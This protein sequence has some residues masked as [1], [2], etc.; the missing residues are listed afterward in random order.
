MPA[1]R[2]LAR[3]GLVALVIGTIAA[4]ATDPDA[5]APVVT[6]E[7]PTDRIPVIID[8]DLD[9]SDIGAILVMLR[10]PALDVRA[11][12]ISGTGLIHCQA[13]RLVTRFLI[14]ELGD[15]DIPFGC[16][17]EKGGPDARP[18]PDDWRARAD[19]AF[20]FD[21]APTVE[22]GVPLDAVELIRETV[23]TSPSAPT[24]VALG[25]LTNLEDAFAA[26]PT[27]PD[28]LAGVHAMLG[29]I[30]APGNVFVDGLDA[31]DPLEW[32]AFA[33]P[34]AVEAVFATDVP[35]S[36]VPLD[37]TDDVPVPVDLADRLATD[38]ASAAAD[39]MY[40]SLVRNPDRLRP[41]QGQQL[42]DELAAL[43]L[44]EPDLVTWDEATVSV[45]EDGRLTRDEA[46]RTIRYA[47]AA[48]PSA[49]ESAL[50]A[51]L[52]R[53][54]PR[55]TPFALAGSLAVTFDGT[56]CAISGTSDDTGLHELRYEGAP[57]HPE[58]GRAR[59]GPGAASL[60]GRAHARP[61]VRRDGA[62]AR[63]AAVRPD[64]GRRVRLGRAGRGHGRPRGRH[65]WSRL[66][67]RAR[68]PM[69]SSRPGSPFQT[70]SGAVGP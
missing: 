9:L 52:R 58:R 55:A 6:G 1:L 44:T 65:L 57:G 10:D 4:C 22:A 3:A 64:G 2:H 67:G 66:P 40:E 49:V 12:T 11:I 56:T 68:S 8:A 53:G 33:D 62:A 47:T 25:P 16:G 43:A 13:G 61:D 69:S 23:D 37:A 59:G 21:I 42:W 17:R 34:S 26:D 18:F 63:L 28:R 7:P 36:I 14:D 32:N 46:G 24:I 70:G 48:D 35:I 20:G 50:L 5:S 31:E 51:A 27:L 41:D 19:D 45:G 60:G 54:E 39:V 30:D 15:P 29:T 38:R